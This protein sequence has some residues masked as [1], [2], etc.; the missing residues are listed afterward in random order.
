MVFTVSGRVGLVEDGRMFGKS[1][2]LDDV[3]RM[4]AASA[5][6]VIGVNGSASDGGDGVVDES[7]FIQRVGVNRDLDVDTRRPHAGSVDRGGRRAP[8]LVQLQAACSGEDLFRQRLARG[9]IAFA[10][11]SEVHGPGFSGA[12]HHAPG[13]NGPACRWWRWFQW[14]GRFHRRS[15]W[16]C[17]SKALRRFAAAR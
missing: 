16:W 13:S 2:N 12:K 6:G 11:K 10:E 9:C 7:R 3:R 4:A 8:V 17:R 15:W 1:G 5:F 14:R